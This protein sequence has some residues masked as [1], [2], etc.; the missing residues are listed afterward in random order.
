MPRTAGSSTADVAFYFDLASPLAYLAAERVAQVL[1]RDSIRVEW[2]PVLARE[3]LATE[4][5][6]IESLG[7][8]SRNAQSQEADQPGGAS[9]S[10]E[11]RSEI[12][13]RAVRQG[14]LPIRWPD[15]L[16][17]DSTLAMLA[18]TY[19]KSIGRAIPF[20]QAAFRQAFA[21]GRSLAEPDNVVIAAAACELHPTAVLRGSRLASVRDRLSASTTA[22]SVIGVSY[23]PAV[24]IGE[25][26]FA[27][28]HS[29]EDAAE[30]LGLPRSGAATIEVERR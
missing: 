14:L 13:L 11:L 2:Q 30:S 22:A 24:R 28:E 21:A 10:E 26:V 16:P 27:G 19:A 17:F 25:R 15:E 12:E 1:G 8:W 18:A 6:E 5:P 20:A 23:V 3:L 9:V 29:V 4:S 7:V